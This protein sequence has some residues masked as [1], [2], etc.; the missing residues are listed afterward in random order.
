MDRIEKT[1]EFFGKQG[2]CSQAILA[3]FGPGFG[4]DQGLAMGLGRSLGGGMGHLGLVCGAVSAGMLI[5][6]LAS[7]GSDDE[8]QRRAASYEAV[9][10]FSERF[11]AL[12][13]SVQCRDLLGLNLRDP[14]ELA[15]ARE[16]GLFASFCPGLVR[17][18]SRL[19]LELTAREE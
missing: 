5:L 10:A 19:L 4:L 15:Q 8:A 2:N 14:R 13:G 7:N 17:D 1:V 16:R 18:V 12:H 6:G 9:Q 3:T 11:A